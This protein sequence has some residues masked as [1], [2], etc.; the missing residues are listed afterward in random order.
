ML[1]KKII[2]GIVAFVWLVIATVLEIITGI[3]W[4]IWKTKIALFFLSGQTVLWV[5]IIILFV[6]WKHS[7]KKL[8]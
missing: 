6:L 3:A 1:E 5:T 4:L 7:V 2:E 8:R